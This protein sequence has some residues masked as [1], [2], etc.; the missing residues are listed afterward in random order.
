MTLAE[1]YSYCVALTKR[2]ARNFHYA[3]S[4]LPPE[5]YRGICALYAFA[6]ISDDISDEEA[7]RQKALAAT[8]AWRSA[9]DRALAGD[10][11]P[12]PVWPALLDTLRRYQIPAEYLHE[13]I[14]G[15]EMDARQNRYEKWEDARLYCYRVASVVGMMTVHVLGF[16]DKKIIPLA[17]KLGLA[18]QLTN[19]LR[20]LKEDAARNRIYLPLEDLR[21]QGV[22][23]AEVLAARP[24]PALLR[25]V[26]FE[27]A[28]ARAF[29]EEGQQVVPLIEPESRNA[30]RCLV[31]IY[32]RLLGKIELNNDVWS[33]R[34]GLSAAEKT[35]LALGFAFRR[36][37]RM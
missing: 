15:T 18:F 4:V 12:E 28:R 35:W 7:D 37:L 5:R 33:R 3:F 26:K 36:F 8:Q 25:L 19:I 22:S 24:T 23:E 27:A 34:A 21:G 29:Y 17:E 32:S 14:T 20:D 9:F 30:L 1:S 16:T 31:A 10:E 6:R 13:L 2:T 11:R